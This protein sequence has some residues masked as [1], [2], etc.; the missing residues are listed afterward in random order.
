MLALPALSALFVASLSLELVH[1]H[2]PHHHN[3]AKRQTAS[4]T[5]ATSSATSAAT[6][7]GTVPASSGTVPVSSGAAAATTPITSGMPAG[8]AP[9][10]RT[11]F[12][13]GA[14]PSYSG[15]PALPTAFVFSSADWPL[16]DK[17]PPTDSPQVKEW[18]KELD[19][20][21]IPDLDPTVG[22]ATC[23]ENPAASKDAAARGWWTCGHYVADTDVVSCPDKLTWGISFDDGPSTYTPKVLNFLDDHDLHATFFVVGS[24]VVS[25]PE[26]LRTEYMSGHEIAVHTW[27]HHALTTMTNEQIVAELGWTRH[28]I[29]KVIGVTPTLMR[30]PRGDI[31]NR[32]RAISNA[33]GLKPVIW[34]NGP[35]GPF[36]TNDWRVE[37]GSI[38]NGEVQFGVFQSLLGNATLI[39]T[40]FI[41][42]EH[43][44]FETTVDLA[45]GYTLQSALSHNP[46]FKLKAIGECLAI[47]TFDLYQET[48]VTKI[49]NSTGGNKNSSGAA[50]DTSPPHAQTHVAR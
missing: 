36:D 47:P 8:A 37:D 17:V 18:M 19:G 28:A 26:M 43:D 20:V 29:Q 48:A 9:T 31:D 15:A 5:T 34:T 3:L 42:L 7:S 33:M 45:V 21:D 30:P 46:A 40:G 6:T 35:A 10:L 13:A 49:T 4:G 44:L 22:D 50:N 12:A 38:A 23:E 16:L 1:A 24:R 27:S 32:V 25:N 41:V 11:T 2:N 14:T 39:D